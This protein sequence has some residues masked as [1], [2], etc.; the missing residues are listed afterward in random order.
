M[1]APTGNRAVPV[2][3]VDLFADT[4]LVDP[5]PMHEDLRES[6]AVVYLERY[7]VWA[8]ARHAEVYAALTDYETF[9]SSVGG[10]I[11]SRSALSAPA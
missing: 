2:L 7:R 5:Y 9:C 10:R 1:P 3:D 8:M 4:N 11:R 6:G